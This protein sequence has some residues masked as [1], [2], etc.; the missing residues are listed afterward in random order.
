MKDVLKTV[1]LIL[2]TC[3]FAFASL[4]IF[5]VAAVVSLFH[6]ECPHYKKNCPCCKDQ[7]G[8]ASSESTKR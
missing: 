2:L 8:K 3:I 1:A 4:L 7:T 5:A 6:E